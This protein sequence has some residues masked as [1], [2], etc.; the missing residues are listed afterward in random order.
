MLIKISEQNKNKPIKLAEAINITKCIRDLIN[1]ITAMYCPSIYEGDETSLIVVRYMEEK[2][3]MVQLYEIMMEIVLKETFNQRF[4]DGISLLVYYILY[5]ELGNAFALGNMEKS[6]RGLQQKYNRSLDMWDN[7]E[8]S[9]LAE[10]AVYE[11]SRNNPL[12]RTRVQEFADVFYEKK[13]IREEEYEQ[14]CNKEINFWHCI[15]RQLS[16]GYEALE[17]CVTEE[18]EITLCLETGEV[19]NIG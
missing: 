14:A 8:D 17:M 18:D 1:E 12:V 13:K 15:E 11:N 2:R 4:N 7:I 9:D 10:D 3:D 5:E 16:T 6:Y 19:L